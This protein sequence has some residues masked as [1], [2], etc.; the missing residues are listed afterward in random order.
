MNGQTDAVLLVCMSL[1]VGGGDGEGPSLSIN[2]LELIALL[3][4]YLGTCL[5][6]NR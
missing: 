6:Q 3:C 2:C 4:N 5:L 1:N